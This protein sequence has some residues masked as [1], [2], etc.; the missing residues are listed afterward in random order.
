[1]FYTKLMHAGT[2]MLGRAV[3]VVNK[4]AAAKESAEAQHTT[5]SSS[6]ETVFFK[7]FEKCIRIV[8]SISSNQGYS[9]FFEAVF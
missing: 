2:T 9:Y 4:F 5:L 1:M 8:N 6:S 3:L 7:T